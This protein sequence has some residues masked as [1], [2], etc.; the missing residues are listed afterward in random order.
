MDRNQLLD[1]QEIAIRVSLDG[2]QTTM[3]TALPA[4]VVSVNLLTMTIICQPTIQGVI[5]NPDESETI[6]N[7]PLL[8]DVPICYPSCS[9]FMLT[10]PL[11]P[12]DEVLVVFSSRAIDSWWQQG[13][14]QPPIETRMHDLSDGFAIPGPKS[15]P[16]VF[17]AISPTNVQLRNKLG[18]TYLEIT[19]TG[20]INMVAPTGVT[21]TGPLTV[22]GSVTMTGAVAITGEVSVT[23]DISATGEVM[24]TEVVASVDVMA[25]AVS[26]LTHV[27][28]GVTPG[29]G[30][31]GPPV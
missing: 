28:S 17:T 29:P 8:G 30:V 9:N 26:L 23:G 27:H 25:G 14:V 15:V 19:P 2:R 12:G 18:T 31:S 16:Q 20:L 24:A 11:L 1:S 21:V 6:V 13:G 10:M 4:I 22:T 7:L 5:T 3:W